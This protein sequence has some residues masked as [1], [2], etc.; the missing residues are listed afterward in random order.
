MERDRKG[1]GPFGWFVCSFCKSEFSPTREPLVVV[2][3]PEIGG[4]KTFCS[5]GCCF[6]AGVELGQRSG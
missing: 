1:G 4:R 3:A 2:L 5:L 6:F